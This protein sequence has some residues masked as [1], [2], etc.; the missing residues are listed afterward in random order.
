MSPSKRPGP[1]P[2]PVRLNKF[3]A[4][5][6]VASRREADRLIE[7]GRVRVNGRVV[8]ELG[9]RIDPVR[10][11]VEADG[12]PVKGAPGNVHILLHKP[13]N[14]VTTLKDPFG[15]RTVRDILP[16][17]GAR[18]FPVGRLDADSRGALLLTNDGE[19][20]YR[21]THPKFE[22]WKTY[23]AR[24]EGCPDETGL[25]TLRRGVFIE[26]RKTAPAR[27]SV[28]R[29]E[30]T[31]SIVQVEIREGRKR[32]VRH[33]LEAVGCPVQELTRTNFAGLTVEGLKPGA[34]RRLRPDEIARLH[35]LAGLD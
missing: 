30:R 8:S 20:A 12:R 33:M 16:D 23:V 9:T 3:L 25:E 18:V 26:G 1:S 10:D 14:V 32:E 13:E 17:V 11:R 21:L 28:L 29:R 22:I 24:V 6:G 4:G 27:A 35:R 2:G 15:R 5:S 34:W 19:L 31:A 7:A